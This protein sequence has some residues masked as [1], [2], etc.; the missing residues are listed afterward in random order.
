MILSAHQPH[1]CP[2][3]GHIDKIAR[4]DQ[5]VL[6]DHVQYETENFQNRN[7]I[8]LPSGAHWLTVPLMAG[9][10]DEAICDKRVS[11]GNPA[12]PENMWRTIEQGYIKAPYF[13]RYAPPLQQLL[14]RRW[15]RLVDLDLAILRLCLD[16]LA[17]R[18][19]L[20]LSSTLAP[21]AKKSALIV[22]LCERLGADT[23]L[24]GMGGSQRY[25]DMPMFEAHSVRVVWQAFELPPYPQRFPRLGF[26]PR[27][28]TLDLLFNCG[29]DSRAILLG[30]PRAAA[31]CAS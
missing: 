10:R 3:P 31:G 4:C 20:V 18:T 27:L 14:L 13:A 11:Y 22:E 17:I 9:S 19:P 5:F 28:S 8:K 12:W 16:W 24:G 25:F 29:P 26:V 21:V 7:R 23:F 30:E 1:F 15:D 6:L 2:W